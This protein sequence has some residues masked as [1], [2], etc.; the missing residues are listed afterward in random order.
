MYC[1]Q[2]FIS[3][4]K[5]IFE[6]TIQSIIE[7]FHF[8][9]IAWINKYYRLKTMKLKA[10]SKWLWCGVCLWSLFTETKVLY[11][12]GYFSAVFFLSSWPLLLLL[13]GEL[14]L[15]WLL[16]F[17]ALLG[18]PPN[19]HFKKPLF[20]FLPC[21]IY[22]YINMNTKKCQRTLGAV[23][24]QDRAQLIDDFFQIRL[25]RKIEKFLIWQFCYLSKS[26]RQ[27]IKL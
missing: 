5:H 16:L 26:Y 3:A 24:M 17:S 7:W 11:Y 4:N 18:E 27:K 14:Q 8:I 15:C 20:G 12:Q 22:R 9:N 6:S 21:D 19:H 25:F 1:L 2:Y 10:K 13:A 23:T